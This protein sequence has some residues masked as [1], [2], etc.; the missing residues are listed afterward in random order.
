[1]Q[2]EH[3]SLSRTRPSSSPWVLGLGAKVGEQGCG[4]EGMHCQEHAWLSLAWF[5]IFLKAGI[6]STI[7]N[8]Y[9]S[10]A[11]P[12]SSSSTPWGCPQLCLQKLKSSS[13]GTRGCQEYCE[14]SLCQFGIRFPALAQPDL[15]PTALSGL[16]SKCSFP[17]PLSSGVAEGAQT[18]F[19][20]T[21]CHLP[22]QTRCV[23]GTGISPPVLCGVEKQ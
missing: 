7:D 10:G 21:L 14:V 13:K 16:P 12:F 6:S 19:L 15:A 2:S 9:E 11:D 22:A 23:C 20:S 5:N 18:V 8:K 3:F 1:M 17:S 4:K